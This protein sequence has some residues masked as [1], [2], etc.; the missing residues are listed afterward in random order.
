MFI[1]K[2][3]DLLV[4]LN[5]FCCE[6]GDVMH[7]R[8]KL[9]Q[10][11][12]VV[13]AVLFAV[14]LISA[15]I[16]R[17]DTTPVVVIANEELDVNKPLDEQAAFLT[18]KEIST[19]ELKE[20]NGKLVTNYAEL[21]GAKLKAKLSVGSPIPKDLLTTTK[22]AGQFAY[23][24][25]K[26]HSVFLLQDAISTLPPGVEV[27]DKISIKLIFEDDENKGEQ[28]IGELVSDARIANIAE[29]NVW[30]FVS[31]NDFNKLSVSREFGSFVLTLPG[32]KEVGVCAEVK[33]KI[34]SDKEAK[35]AKTRESKEFLNAEQKVQDEM[36]EKIELEFKL[37][38]DNAECVDPTDKGG[39]IHSKDIKDFIK[40]NGEVLEDDVFGN[41][42]EMEDV[43]DDVIT[44]VEDTEN[45]DTENEENL[46]SDGN[47][48]DDNF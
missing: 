40:A 22:M 19:K 25:P 9:L 8:V 16:G 24:T 43:I 31:D 30:V 13:F 47:S 45:S 29:Q 41:Q 46:N 36:I 26:D 23:E 27:G 15:L 11:L 14:L 4:F 7:K 44:D 34:L 10:T 38:L 1:F 33:E 32:V 48:T 17:H 20:F 6:R 28:Y 39:T 37:R 5:T 35:L 2:I 42:D 12:V 18:I 21:K 3:L